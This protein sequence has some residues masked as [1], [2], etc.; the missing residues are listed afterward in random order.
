MRSST[1]H[2]LPCGWGASFYDII[3]SWKRKFLCEVQGGWGGS[4]SLFCLSCSVSEESKGKCTYTS[5][6]SIWA[7]R[8]SI[9]L[10]TFV[11]LFTKWCIIQ[12]KLSL[13]ISW[14]FGNSWLR[15]PPLSLSPR[16]PSFMMIILA[17][18]TRLQTFLRGPSRLW[19]KCLC[20]SAVQRV[21]F[22]DKRTAPE[23]RRSC[24]RS[25]NMR[26]AHHRWKLKEFKLRTST[27]IPI[28]PD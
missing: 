12:L 13:D 7:I 22:R 21:T 15:H 17:N 5:N 1:Q 11:H 25:K 10:Y 23:K 14:K 8:H 9:Y 6:L 27:S 28:P 3:P 26:K 18:W 20:A 19:G 4:N 16:R 2:A 24:Y